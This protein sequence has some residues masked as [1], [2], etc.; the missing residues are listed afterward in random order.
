MLFGTT[1]LIVLGLYI[2]A[3]VGVGFLGKM[4]QK[5]NSL[6]DFYLGGRSMGL[7][8]LFLT[9]YATQYSGNTLI[10][11]AGR[12]YRN[13]YQALYSVTF[14]V[15]V[16]G[17][18]LVYAPKLFKLSRQNSFITVSDYIH[19]RFRN[20][21]LT[22]LFSV[23]C[24][25][26][27]G[28][29]VL[30]NL[31]AL[32]YIVEMITDG[33]IGFTQSIIGLSFIIVVY[34]TLGGMR[35]VAWSDTFQGILL[36]IGCFFII[37]AIQIYYGG[38]ETAAT[39]IRDNKAALWEVPNWEQK[40][41][42]FSSLFLGFFGIAI[43]PHAIQRIYAAKN[44]KT[45][46]RSFQA[47]ALMPMFTTFFIIIVGI[48][49]ISKFP[50]L[51]RLESERVTI[52]ILTDIAQQNPSL[53]IMMVLFLIAVIAAIMSTID[54]ALLSI[55]SIGTQDIYRRYAKDTSQKNLTRMGKIFSWVI[56]ALMAWL[57]ITV[58]QTIWRLFE[59][60]LEMLI[61][62]APSLLL[63]LYFPKLD[64]R[65]ILTGMIAGLVLMFIFLFSQ[66]F[67]FNIPTTPFG[68]HGGVIG[69]FVN[70]GLVGVVDYFL[71][72]QR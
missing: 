26:V 29:Y 16:I 69:L 32:G 40:K 25:I 12:A 6:A 65:A 45:L 49:A 1:E 15:A 35:S 7:L 17:C 56:M 38:L 31:K 42:W 14:M 46:K 27:L 21:T 60:K 70:F 36:M 37:A 5:E 66:D 62:L 44:S 63:G 2:A 54:S 50:D 52:M 61:Q 18:Y 43:Y 51:S 19:F 30:T 64:Y 3:L 41:Y 23:I 67:G 24:I 48:V 13:G 8:V 53:R 28:N 4:A 59:I 10:G 20:N 47:M 22:I 72:T 71:K 55:S 57:A 68:M 58:P 11:F 34:E 9:L 39:Y 33:R